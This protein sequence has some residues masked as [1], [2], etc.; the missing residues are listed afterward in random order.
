MRTTTLF[1]AYAI[2]LDMVASVEGRNGEDIGCTA[3]ENRLIRQG[4]KLGR[5]LRRRMSEYDH[6]REMMPSASVPSRWLANAPPQELR[7]LTDDERTFAEALERALTE[8][9]DVWQAL[10]DRDA[11]K[12]VK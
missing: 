3:K 5:E 8:N 2:G 7:E 1:N 6:W 11:G 9:A 12:G 10:A 4:V